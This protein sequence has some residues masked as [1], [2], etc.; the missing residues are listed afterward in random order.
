MYKT[1]FWR[2][3]LLGTPD[4]GG[5]FGSRYFE[6]E[7]IDFFKSKLRMNGIYSGFRCITVGT[8]VGEYD[9]LKLIGG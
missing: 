5:L 3:F 9:V 8:Q 6:G 2:V 4:G 1:R 7:M